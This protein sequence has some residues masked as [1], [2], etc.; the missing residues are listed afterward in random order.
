MA[1]AVGHRGMGDPFAEHSAVMKELY[2]EY[3]RKDEFDNIAMVEALLRETARVAH[4]KEASC[5]ELIQGLA[6]STADL[7]VLA[8]Y[9]DAEGA[10]TKRAAGLSAAVECASAEAGSLR[11]ELRALEAAA[12]A[13]DAR[14]CE[15]VERRAEVERAAAAEEPI[16][17]YQLSL[18]AHI[19]RINW[20]FDRDDRVAGSVSDPKGGDLRPFD[21]DPSSMDAS[22]VVNQLW[23]L[24]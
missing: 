4:S 20:R 2:H 7:E 3:Q 10:H 11:H 15:A 8:T 21:M 13:A 24:L 16:L 14:M 5:Q 19:S 17:R 6:K 22:A 1:T 12:A 23:A 9:P 18:Y